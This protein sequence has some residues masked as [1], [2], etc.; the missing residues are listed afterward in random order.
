M[1]RP[2]LGLLSRRSRSALEGDCHPRYRPRLEA[3][4]DRLDV[5]TLIGL[6]VGAAA[7]QLFRF[8][9]A[10]PGTVAQI[11]VTGLAGGDTLVGMDFR[12]RTGQ[13]MGVAVNGNTATV[14]RIDALT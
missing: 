10:T 13:L 8:D 1:L 2:L 6:G 7:N 5:A 9:N 3:L 12:P 11:A 4:E 14:Y